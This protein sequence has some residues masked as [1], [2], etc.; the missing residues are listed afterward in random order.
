MIVRFT[1]WPARQARSSWRQN[2]PPPADGGGGT[3]A[4][5]TDLDGEQ[6][7]GV[8]IVQKKQLSRENLILFDDEKGPA[9]TETKTKSRRNPVRETHWH[10]AAQLRLAKIMIAADAPV[11]AADGRSDLEEFL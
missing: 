6:F 3:G 4:G 8:R 7:A 10:P 2:S 11:A 1:E 9:I 5:I